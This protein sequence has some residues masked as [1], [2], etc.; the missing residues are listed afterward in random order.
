MVIFFCN[1]FPF[2]KI[3]GNRLKINENIF[4][5]TPGFQ[6]LII[7]TSNIPMKKVKIKDRELIIK[8]LESLDFENYEAIRGKSKSGRYKQ[9]KSIF[10][11]RIVEG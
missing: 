2:E 3:G 8:I 1:G 11:K 10:K 5:I 6:K 4:G 9:S 7:D